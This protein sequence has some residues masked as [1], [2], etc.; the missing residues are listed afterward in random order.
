MSTV[1]VTR[2][3]SRHQGNGLYIPTVDITPAGEFGDIKVILEPGMSLPTGEAMMKSLYSELQFFNEHK[4]YLL[5]A[6]DPSLMVAAGA[7]L[8][9]R[10]KSFRIL[11]W[12]RSHGRYRPITL[13]L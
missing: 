12:D 11:S 4:D 9:K 13:E 1:Y 7:I 3:P 8:G 10:C 2:V 6:S 5:P